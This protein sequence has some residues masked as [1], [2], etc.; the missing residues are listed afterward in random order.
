MPTYV[1]E[2]L[3][4]IGVDP[5]KVEKGINTVVNN[6]RSGLTSAITNVVVPAVAGLA[7]GELVQQFSQE[8]VQVDR[9]SKSLGMNIEQLSAWRTAAELA[10]VEAD[11][12]GELFAD[13]NDWMVDSAMNDSGAMN[14]FIKQGLLPAVTDVNGE[15]KNTEQYILEMADAFKNMDP[16]QASGI[17]RQIGLSN[18]QVAQWIQQGGDALRAQLGQAKQLGTFAE[19]DAQAAKEFNASVMALQ[20]SLRMMLLPVFRAIAPVLTKI[21]DGFREISKHIAVFI[22]FIT[23]AGVRIAMMMTGVDKLGGSITKLGAKFKSAWK[24]MM[25]PWGAILFALLA[26][27]LVLDDFITWLEGGE[28]KWGEYYEAIFGGAENAKKWL[29]DLSEKI[30]EIG[31]V[32]EKLYAPIMTV[33]VGFTML[34]GVVSVIKNVVTAIKALR[35][36]MM[37]ALAFTGPWGMALAALGVIIAGL[38]ALNWDEFVQNIQGIGERISQAWE[39]VKAAFDMS[40]LKERFMADVAD[41]GADF[42]AAFSGVQE[43]INGFVS[44]FTGCSEQMGATWDGLVQGIIATWDDC[45]GQ[46]GATWDGLVQGAIDTWN[47]FVN[48]IQSGID[49]IK[50][51]FDTLSS[52]IGG[53]LSTIGASS[54]GQAVSQFNSVNTTNNNYNQRYYY[55][56]GGDTAGYDGAYP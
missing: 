4:G 42:G 41:M 13:I 17:A 28:T 34:T 53:F 30:Q 24:F 37:A 55:G 21:A 31:A 16:A 54:L 35:I 3:I 2:F 45:V 39:E 26:I 43:F 10:G 56:G 44:F 9:L 1:D 29:S 5:S 38:I 48:G 27:G 22:P 6:V 20:H 46:I 25:G 14:D 51:A 18:L 23:A 52:I 47:T 15:M 50:G 32:L 7:S 49:L 36:A 19:E 33:V 40:A 12:V 11:E 8:I